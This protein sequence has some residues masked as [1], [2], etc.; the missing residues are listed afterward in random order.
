MSDIFNNE[1]VV[2]TPTA[3]EIDPVIQKRLSDKDAYIEQLQRE[4][5]QAREELE[6]RVAI[7]TLIK[8]ATQVQPSPEPKAETPPQ[9]TPTP[10]DMAKQVKAILSNE[11]AQANAASNLNSVIDRLVSI[12]GDDNKAQAIIDAKA[13]ELGVGKEFLRASAA[14]SP[15]AFYK[16]IGLEDIKV[17]PT[18]NQPTTG[19]NSEALRVANPN[20]QSGW[21]YY[22]NLRRENPNRYFSPAVQNQIFREVQEGKLQLP[23]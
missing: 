12:Y 4:A 19:M 1:P 21:D 16:L 15:T 23:G 7:E 22:N 8:N 2:E 14:Q 13:K 10:E 18:A 3:P 5:K 9:V 11:S 6:Q 20:A 17:T